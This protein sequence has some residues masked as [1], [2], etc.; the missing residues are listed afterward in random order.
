M[1]QHQSAY[2]SAI[3]ECFNGVIRIRHVRLIAH[4]YA[5]AMHS[6]YY[7]YFNRGEELRLLSE[8]VFSI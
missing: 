8:F 3:I 4:F 2:V 1:R 6:E 7:I 5:S